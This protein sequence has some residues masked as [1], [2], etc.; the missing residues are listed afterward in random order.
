MLD[1]KEIIY[2]MH[3]KERICRIL[4]RDNTGYTRKREDAQ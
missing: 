3:E 1:I 2:R 4:E